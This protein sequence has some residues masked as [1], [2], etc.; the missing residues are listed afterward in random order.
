MLF[1]SPTFTL[2]TCRVWFLYY[3]LKYGEAII[4]YSWWETVVNNYQNWF[5][6]HKRKYGSFKRYMYK[7]I[8]IFMI[9]W[10]SIIFCV[11][12]F[13]PSLYILSITIIPDLFWA[14]MIYCFCKFVKQIIMLVIHV[15]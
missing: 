4:S 10:I 7:R 1:V 6:Q 8:L 13:K 11:A 2:I 5:I 9:I 12:Y 3:D 15:M 14:F